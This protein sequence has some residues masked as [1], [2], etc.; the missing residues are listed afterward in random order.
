MEKTRFQKAVEFLEEK[1]PEETENF[2]N[3][4]VEEKLE[5]LYFVSLMTAEVV[6]R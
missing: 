5:Y 1:Y 2:R 6:R 4:S 3:M